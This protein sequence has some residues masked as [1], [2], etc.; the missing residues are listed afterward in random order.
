MN[1]YNSDDE[2]YS[3]VY[4]LTNTRFEFSFNTPKNKTMVPIAGLFRF[5]NIPKLQVEGVQQEKPTY[6]DKLANLD[7]S[8]ADLKKYDFADDKSPPVKNQTKN[9]LGPFILAFPGKEDNNGVILPKAIGPDFKM[10]K[11]IIFQDIYVTKDS[12]DVKKAYQMCDSFK[13]FIAAQIFSKRVLDPVCDKWGKFR[14]A[15]GKPNSFFRYEVPDGGSRTSSHLLALAVD[16]QWTSAGDAL[17][18]AYFWLVQNRE[19]LGFDQVI[20]EGNG[21]QWR[22]IHLG[23][24]INGSNRKQ[25]LMTKNSLATKPRAINIAKFTSPN[26]ANFNN[27]GSI[28]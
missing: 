14:G 28:L 3:G 23:L 19:I 24:K 7:A 13:Y 1:F 26:L 8:T 11:H 17:T 25:C 6:N 18:E 20:L 21:S 10:S 5:S 22:W 9:P 2:A 27:V 15:G 4:R 12:T 16:A